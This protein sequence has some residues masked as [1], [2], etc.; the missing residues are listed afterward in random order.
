MTLSTPKKS[1]AHDALRL[2]SQELRPGRTLTSRSG[3]KAVTAEHRGHARLRQDDAS[4]LEFADGPEIAQ[5][6]FS[7][8]SRRT[9]STVS[10]GR[11]GRP[12]RRCGWGQRRLTRERCRWRIVRGV[13]RNEHQRSRGTRPASSAIGSR[14]DQVKRG[15][16]AWRRST[17]SWCRSTRISASLAAE[18]IG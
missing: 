8:A 3:W 5:R 18:S 9:S 11:A 12:G 1:M 7:L 13:M 15:R 14:S 6:G 4:L 2:G 17:A 16:A 10:S